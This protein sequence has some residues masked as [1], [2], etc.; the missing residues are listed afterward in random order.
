MVAATRPSANI[1]PAIHRCANDRHW[2]LR[3]PIGKSASPERQRGKFSNRNR[4]DALT[5][6]VRQLTVN[7]SPQML[8]RLATR[9]TIVEL[10]EEPPQPRL[11]RANLG[12]IHA[13]YSYEETEP[14]PSKNMT[15]AALATKINL[16]L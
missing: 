8:L 15:H 10:L 16:A 2:Q 4:L 11:E 1:Q 12:G 3:P 7:V 5:R 6:Q 9:K 13:W 14:V